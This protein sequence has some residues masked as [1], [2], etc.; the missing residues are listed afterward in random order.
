MIEPRPSSFAARL[1]RPVWAANR[2]LAL[3]TS[4]NDLPS[5]SVA[6][7]GLPDSAPLQL[8]AIC[9]EYECHVDSHRTMMM[10]FFCF[11][12][13]MK[14]CDGYYVLLSLYYR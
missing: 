5:T 2:S 6:S 12:R 4:P 3:T 11:A 7:P 8:P 1:F 10:S 14:R 9:I 13:L